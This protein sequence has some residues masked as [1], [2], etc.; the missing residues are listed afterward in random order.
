MKSGPAVNVVE[1]MV[2]VGWELGELANLFRKPT[3]KLDK[4]R[5]L[6]NIL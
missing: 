4:S 3:S 2:H 1:L 6:E 5:Y